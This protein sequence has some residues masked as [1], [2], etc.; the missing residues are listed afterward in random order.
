MKGM[1]TDVVRNTI[2]KRHWNNTFLAYNNDHNLVKY[3][4]FIIIGDVR[5]KYKIDLIHNYGGF[6]VMMYFYF[7]IYFLNSFLQKK[8]ILIFGNA[9]N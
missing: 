7:Y 8:M 6:V 1:S 4:S 3:D 5:F 2:N 9:Y